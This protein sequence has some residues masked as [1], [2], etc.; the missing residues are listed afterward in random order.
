MVH[1]GLATRDIRLGP[2]LWALT[3]AAP[4]GSDTWAW[5]AEQDDVPPT[6]LDEPVPVPAQKTPEPELTLF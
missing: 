2:S 4:P 5:Q 1:A 6:P 3:G